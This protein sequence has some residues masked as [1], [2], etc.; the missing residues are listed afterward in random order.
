MNIIA[1]LILTRIFNVIADL[2]V[3]VPDPTVS[4][5]KPDPDLKIFLSYLLLKIFLKSRNIEMCLVV[6]VNLFIDEY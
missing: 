3:L 2:R 5:R 1:E 6:V 4:I